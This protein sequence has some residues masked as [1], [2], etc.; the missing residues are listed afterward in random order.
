MASWY[1]VSTQTLMT[2]VMSVDCNHEQ[3][4]FCDP[5]ESLEMPTM[6]KAHG[7][8]LS[9][10]GRQRVVCPDRWTVLLTD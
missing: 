10:Q 3:F 6:L 5:A 4:V 8:L 2:V 7:V 9:S 1:E